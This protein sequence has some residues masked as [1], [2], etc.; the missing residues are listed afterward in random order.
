MRLKLNQLTLTEIFAVV[1]LTAIIATVGVF[2]VIQGIERAA[3]TL[4][5]READ[6]NRGRPREPVYETYLIDDGVSYLF[7]P[8]PAL[9]GIAPRLW[10]DTVRRHSRY[11]MEQK[12]RPIG[13]GELSRLPSD[14]P[15]TS[16]SRLSP[17]W[18]ATFSPWHVSPGWLALDATKPLRGVDWLF[19][20][21]G[22]HG[23][24][25]WP[26]FYDPRLAEFSTP[27]WPLMHPLTA[28]AANGMYDPTN[29][30][31]NGGAWWIKQ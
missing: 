7:Y 12:I 19:A 10:P 20:S 30:L 11:L 14:D 1:A 5:E 18:E 31:V 22:L 25:D 8:V 26:G 15:F 28:E 3:V 13:L 23:G 24:Y 21:P 17:D 27:E 29:G 16:A 6:W 9:P 2:L 4:V